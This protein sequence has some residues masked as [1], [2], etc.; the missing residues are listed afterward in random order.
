MDQK[1]QRSLLAVD[2]I[3][4][5]GEW[6]ETTRYKSDLRIHQDMFIAMN[7]T[8]RRLGIVDGDEGEYIDLTPEECDRMIK[9]YDLKREDSP[10]FV[11]TYT[12]RSARSMELVKKLKRDAGLTG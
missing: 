2:I 4:C 1:D 7:Q 6:R 10:V 9:H 8:V 11:D 3:S 12:Y 5:T